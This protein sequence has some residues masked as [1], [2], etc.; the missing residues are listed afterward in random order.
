MP[1][2]YDVGAIGLP[3]PPKPRVSVEGEAPVEV[4]D[5]L[6][7]LLFNDVDPALVVVRGSENEVFGPC[8]HREAALASLADSPSVVA[9]Q[10]AT[11][12][13]RDTDRRR[14]DASKVCVTEVPFC[15]SAPACGTVE[16]EFVVSSEKLC[17]K[18]EHGGS[19]FLYYEWSGTE[20]NTVTGTATDDIRCRLALRLT[21]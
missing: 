6:T 2:C 14:P 20:W 18:R 7:M 15:G 11:S 21:Q 4:T 17:T 9:L 8:G 19:L 12:T 13:L 16:N 5:Y 3:G 10:F 1:G